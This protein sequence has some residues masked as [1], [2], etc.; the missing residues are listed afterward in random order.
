[1]DTVSYLH[2]KTLIGPSPL[3]KPSAISFLAMV[4]A[5]A[6]SAQPPMGNQVHAAAALTLT[7]GA[8][9]E[10]GTQVPAAAAP[11]AMARTATIVAA[12]AAHSRTVPWSLAWQLHLES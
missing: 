3:N 7:T 10:G 5:V 2:M 6:A 11:S 9:V 4:A 1:M 8:I 12:A